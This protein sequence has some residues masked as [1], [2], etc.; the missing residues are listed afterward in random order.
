[1]SLEED[2]KRPQPTAEEGR[3]VVAFVTI[4]PAMAGVEYNALRLA[5]R[6]DPNCWHVILVCPQEGDLP[7]A[8]RKADLEVRI[9][10]RPRLF[11]TSI[12]IG[13]KRR[14]PN[15]FACACGISRSFCVRP[16]I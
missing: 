6:L 13:M 1:M 8:F 14:V 12:Q 11:S 15:P 16:A 5:E 9:L 7:A 4:G 2:Q 3:R 10:P